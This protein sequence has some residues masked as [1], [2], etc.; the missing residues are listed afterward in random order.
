MREKVAKNSRLSAGNDMSQGDRYSHSDRGSL[1][2]M[3]SAPDLTVLVKELKGNTTSE[4][5]NLSKVK[6]D[7][8]ISESGDP[9]DNK[10]DTKLR[11]LLDWPQ[12]RRESSTANQQS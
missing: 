1:L 5:D 2:S 6:P 12:M 11:Q 7:P 4:Q 9:T 3:E 8:A 10:N